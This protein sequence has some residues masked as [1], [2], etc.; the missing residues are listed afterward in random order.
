[1]EFRYF[2]PLALDDTKLLG[3]FEVTAHTFLDC[4]MQAQRERQGRCLTVD[5]HVT[6]LGSYG[7]LRY[8]FLRY[9]KQEY[10]FK[11]LFTHLF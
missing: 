9:T 11:L 8:Y 5:V 3:Y 6:T 10:G 2:V 7:G 4:V 1:M